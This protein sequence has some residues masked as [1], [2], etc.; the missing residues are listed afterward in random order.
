MTAVF[1]VL[2]LLGLF[3]GG[4][5]LVKGASGIAER[6]RVPP[7]VIGLTVVGF[8]T[9][10]PELLVSLQAALDGLPGIAIGNVVG[11]N[12][13]NILLIL[14]VSAVIGPLVSP[15]AK[16]RRDLM[17]ML[18]A[19]VICVP[20]F[21]GGVVGRLEGAILVASIVT[22]ILINLRQAGSEPPGETEAPPMF[23]SV[24]FALGG[25]AAVLIGA[26]LLVD[27]A[28]E[29]ARTF[30]VSDAMIGLT[31]VAVGTSLPELATSIMAAVRGE[32]EIALGNVLGSN[33]FNIFAIMGITALVL[34]IP[35]DPR[36]LTF[37][38]PVMVTVSVVLVALMW[39]RGSL[40]R[41]AGVGFLAVYAA[42]I[43]SG[44]TI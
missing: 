19:A 7:L 4:D 21:L 43:A 30:G 22:Y 39:M 29:I 20:L 36:F 17:W 33:V 27:S 14:G 37:D 34:P 28:S 38:V 2:G 32:R 35:V 23:M 25:L 15:F 31:V 5:W 3:F 41:L 13:A 16:I 9:S 8:G 18:A 6:F 1:F 11:S 44:A 26:R 42:Y 24:L 12:I 40:G 10:T